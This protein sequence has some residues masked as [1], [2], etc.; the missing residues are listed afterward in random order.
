MWLIRDSLTGLKLVE[1]IHGSAMPL[2]VVD[3]DAVP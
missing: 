3:R 1:T 2:T